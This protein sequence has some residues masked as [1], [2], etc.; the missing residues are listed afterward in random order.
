M[1][2]TPCY[3]TS[4][5]IGLRAGNAKDRVAAGKELASYYISKGISSSR[6]E[7]QRQEGIGIG[8]PLPSLK[9]IDHRHVVNH[10]ERKKA[11]DRYIP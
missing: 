1:P 5:L 3:C 6:N 10:T 9:E 8:T 7:R 2:G 4:S 11:Q